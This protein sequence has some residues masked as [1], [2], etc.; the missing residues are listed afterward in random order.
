M[1]FVELMLIS[2][3]AILIAYREVISKQM[4]NYA[5]SM[6][7]LM[8][9]I[10]FCFVPFI[11]HGFFGGAQRLNTNL[12]N[13]HF[14]TEQYHIINVYGLLILLPMICISYLEKVDCGITHS[15][16]KKRIGFNKLFKIAVFLMPPFGLFVFVSSTGMS[17]G[18]IILGGR[19]SWYGNNTANLFLIAISHY[20]FSV[21][22]LAIFVFILAQHKSRFDKVLFL[23]MI[24]S[25]IFYSVL[26]YDRKWIFYFL[27]SVA[28]AFYFVNGYRIKI[29]VR[30]IA[31]LTVL[32]VFV[33]FSQFL[34]DYLLRYMTNTL[35]EGASVWSEIGSWV[36][37]LIVSGDI[38][39]FYR[40]SCE[41]VY[42]T[43][44]NGVVSPGAFIIRNVL[45]FLPSGMSFGIK[46]E[47]VSTTFSV[48]VS[49]GSK[50]REGDMPPGFFGIIVASF[51][52]YFSAII[53]VVFPFFLKFLDS[54]I[55]K[56]ISTVNIVLLSSFLSLLILF[57]RGD[58]SSALYFFIFNVV[59]LKCLLLGIGVIRKAGL[60]RFE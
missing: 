21:V 34:R 32:F 28:G 26:S 52:L 54:Q 45:F 15:D 29:G 1:I 59:L 27:S 22:P 6:F 10:M 13:V 3:L 46:P 56:P 17:L 38:S 44:E 8:Y 4:R 24:S 39:Y 50:L 57:L 33:F 2:L 12:E 43:I 23:L 41:M 53:F 48:L 5:T 37:R 36:E 35:G 49:G 58:D 42:L 20:F 60:W 25:V 55:R 14:F 51:G 9:L 31:V 18:E 47:D 7:I 40:S 11:L 16:L 19:F 30:W